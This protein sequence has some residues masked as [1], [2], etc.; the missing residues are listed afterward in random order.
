M[1]KSL[2]QLC[3]S[4]RH[5]IPFMEYLLK[6]GANVDFIHNNGRSAAFEACYLGAYDHIRLLIQHGA[7]IKKSYNLMFNMTCMDAALYRR[8]YAI[9]ILLMNNGI[10]SN[11]IRERH[12]YFI[13]EYPK[14]NIRLIDP[15]ISTIMEFI[16]TQIEKVDVLPLVYHYSRNKHHQTFNRY[17]NI[18]STL[19]REEYTDIATNYIQ[20]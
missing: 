6:K 16:D 1:G 4:Y 14:D 10:T 11:E 17:P 9:V 7:N 13:V 19:S 3:V 18:L 8:K 2:L 20:F 5:S 12:E 15:T